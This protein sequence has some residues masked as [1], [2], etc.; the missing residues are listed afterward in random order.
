[1][2][3][4]FFLLF[5][6]IFCDCFSQKDTTI[7]GRHYNT[8]MY[9]PYF[10]YKCNDTVKNHFVIG[11]GNMEDSLKTGEWTYYFGNGNIL[12]QGKYK[13]GYKKGRWS[14]MNNEVVN[15]WDRSA[16]GKDFIH[17]NIIN[18]VPEIV[19]VVHTENADYRVINGYLERRSQNSCRR[20]L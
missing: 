13:H 1:M 5:S 7:N 11:I 3:T 2:R 12:A 15:I 14:Y 4:T 9:Y 10:D 20:F 6:L 17:Y 16:K 8:V 18:Q 19:D